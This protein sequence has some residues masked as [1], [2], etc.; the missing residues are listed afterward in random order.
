[1]TTLT[2]GM[3]YT[4][5]DPGKMFSLQIAYGEA[6]E[7]HLFEHTKNSEWTLTLQDHEGVIVQQVLTTMHVAPVLV[8]AP[9]LNSVKSFSLGV[10][11]QGGTCTVQ[12]DRFRVLE[13]KCESDQYLTR[14]NGP[15]MIGE[16]GWTLAENVNVTVGSG[17]VFTMRTGGHIN[18]RDKSSL[19]FKG[20][21][22]QPTIFIGLM[23]TWDT[24]INKASTAQVEGTHTMAQYDSKLSHQAVDLA[25]VAELPPNQRLEKVRAWYQHRSPYQFHLLHWPKKMHWA[26]RF[27]DA[28][29]YF[30]MDVEWFMKW[31]TTSGRVV[32]LRPGNYWDFVNSHF[33]EDLQQANDLYEAKRTAMHPRI[34]HFIN[35][36]EES[37][38][39]HRK[40][41]RLKLTDLFRPGFV[42]AWH[43]HFIKL[44]TLFWLS[45]NTSIVYWD[46]EARELG[47]YERED[48]IEQKFI[49]GVV[50]RVN[51]T[52]AL[53]IE[54][55]GKGR[56]I[57][58]IGL[59]GLFLFHGPLAYPAI[60]PAVFPEGPFQ[61]H[62]KTNAALI[63]G[64]FEAMLH[65]EY[66]SVFT[67]WFPTPSDLE[68]K[69]I[70][71]EKQL[72]LHSPLEDWVRE[73]IQP[74]KWSLQEIQRKYL[75]VNIEEKA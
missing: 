75:S 47:I 17:T 38:A 33:A 27:H 53:P 22:E 7:I 16:L 44:S 24:Y 31:E 11:G 13:G 6:I 68:L 72:Q 74:E 52:S 23:H 12:V 21:K 34:Q 55:P 32:P 10:T 29:L 25:G 3:P 56:A 40:Y 43:T 4:V 46:N 59:I 35:Y 65:H 71:E 37:D 9:K 69:Q 70:L 15:Y 28:A 60:Y 41:G 57:P 67:W 2:D 36:I 49:D 14:Q 19:W 66:S 18:L 30:G 5:Q 42:K 73:L 63:H 20:T 1:M 50:I 51:F 26:D 62:A 58:P 8:Y 64:Y 54:L 45:H 39:W 48:P 61:F